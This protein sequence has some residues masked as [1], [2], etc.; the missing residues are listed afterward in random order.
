MSL[1]VSEPELLRLRL[2]LAGAGAGTGA[3]V[4][5]VTRGVVTQF[6]RNM[7]YSVFPAQVKIHEMDVFTSFI[8]SK[9]ICTSSFAQL[10]EQQRY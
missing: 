1:K 2:T 3:G 9:S 5:P 7:Y 10:L 6:D 8:S 4:S